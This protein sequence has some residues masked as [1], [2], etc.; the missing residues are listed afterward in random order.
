MST[1][2]RIYKLLPTIKVWLDKAERTE[3]LS[4]YESAKNDL[5]KLV[6][7]LADDAC[8]ESLHIQPEDRR[9]L[10]SFEAY[11]ALMQEVARRLGV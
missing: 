9:F 2:E 4:D 7:H 11:E 8:H 5:G 10:C 1:L 6:G 3:S